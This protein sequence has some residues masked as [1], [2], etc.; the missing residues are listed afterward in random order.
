MVPQAD[1]KDVV[2]LGDGKMTIHGNEGQWQMIDR[3]KFMISIGKS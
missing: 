2:F 1:N 3:L